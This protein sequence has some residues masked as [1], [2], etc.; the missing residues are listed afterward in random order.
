MSRAILVIVL[1]IFIIG[2]GPKAQKAKTGPPPP[3]KEEQIRKA[4]KA[5]EELEREAEKPA[6]DLTLEE[7]RSLRKPKEEKLEKYPAQI[8]KRETPKSKYPMKDGFPVWVSNPNYG[9][10]LGGVG[11]AKKI[12][13]K[14]YAEQK[15]LAKHIAIADLAKQ[16]KIIVKTELNKIEIDV[17]TSK[18][19]YYKKKFSA[20]SEQEVRA[21]LIKNAVVEDEW[22]DPRTGE[23]YLWVVIK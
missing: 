5:F 14:G 15:R 10:V 13:G 17:D 4:E 6:R 23:L 3:S 7:G 2:C 9:G 1:G 16:I 11:I 19:R 8:V 22:I 12:P 20:Y 18:L 21:I